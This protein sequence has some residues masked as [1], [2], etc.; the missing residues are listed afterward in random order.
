LKESKKQND[1]FKLLYDN[2]TT[3]HLGA[4]SGLMNNES[5]KQPRM[6][7]ALAFE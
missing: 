4:R 6:D 1:Y 5:S 7:I 2:Q 3:P